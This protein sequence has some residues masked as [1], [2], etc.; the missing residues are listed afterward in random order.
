MQVDYRSKAK[1]FKQVQL[2]TRSVYVFTKLMM[3]TETQKEPLSVLSSNR[4]RGSERILCLQKVCPLPIRNKTAIYSLLKN[5][6][7]SFSMRPEITYPEA[8]PSSLCTPSS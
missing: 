2:R 4:Y 1:F 8:G 6:N 3:R 5:T 7:K